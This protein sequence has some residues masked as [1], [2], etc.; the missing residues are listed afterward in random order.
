MEHAVPMVAGM[1][2][3]MP[4]GAERLHLEGLILAGFDPGE[5]ECAPRS[6]V[7][8]EVAQWCA[9]WHGDEELLTRSYRLARGAIADVGMAVPDVGVADDS[10]FES[11]SSGLS[12]GGG[13]G[14]SGASGDVGSG[15]ESG[16]KQRWMG[17]GS[18]VGTGSVGRGRFVDDVVE[19]GG[20][21][22]GSMISDG[23]NDRKKLDFNKW[24]VLGPG[25][26]PKRALGT[27]LLTGNCAPLRGWI[28][29]VRNY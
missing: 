29:R 19:L 10:L 9:Q 14:S 2:G 12:E 28:P 17:D 21:V 18:A 8:R 22:D 13:G 25:A 7:V 24:Q 1:L 20:T 3:Y 11:G 26:T 23:G 5:L 27:A 16:D 15:T 6:T 4:Y